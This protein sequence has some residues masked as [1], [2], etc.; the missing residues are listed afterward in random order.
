MRIA[1]T[2]AVTFTD[3]ALVA[4][5]LAWMETHMPEVVDCGAEDAELVEL[6]GTPR[7]FEARYHFASREAFARYEQDHVPRLRAEGLRLFPLE[8]GLSY[9]RSLGEVRSVS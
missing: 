4:A 7:T 5:W 9:R 8:K 6:D 3:D 2:V 1:Y